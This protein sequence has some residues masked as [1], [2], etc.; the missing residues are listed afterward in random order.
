LGI[1]NFQAGLSIVAGM[2]LI[3]EGD[4]FSTGFVPRPFASRGGRPRVNVFA[5]LLSATTLACVFAGE[6]VNGLLPCGPFYAYLALAA[7]AGNVFG[8]AVIVS[9]PCPR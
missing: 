4:L 6:L 7:S 8:A 9:A 1:L 5:T 2:F 3:A